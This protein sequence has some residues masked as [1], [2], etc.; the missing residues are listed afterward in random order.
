[1]FVRACVRVCVCVCAK[2]V[3]LWFPNCVSLCTSCDLIHSLYTT[4]SKLPSQTR[5]GGSVT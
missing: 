4:E 3:N 2:R 1:M 5:W